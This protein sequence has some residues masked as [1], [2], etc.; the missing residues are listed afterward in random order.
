MGTYQLHN[1]AYCCD[2]RS[3]ALNPTLTIGPAA[4][5]PLAGQS[6]LAALAALAG[7]GLTRA[8]STVR[9]LRK[10]RTPGNA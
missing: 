2:S 5:A 8:V 1:F 6:A 10:F 7:L 9:A 3:G 4:P